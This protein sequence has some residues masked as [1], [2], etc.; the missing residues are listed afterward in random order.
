MT[1]PNPIRPID[2]ASLEEAARLLRAG[3]VVSFPT[4]TV[5]G[6]GAAATNAEAVAR[7]FELK[8]RPSFDPLIVHFPNRDM[9]GEYA[10]AIPERAEELMERFWP[11]P[12]T[13][14]FPKDERIPDIVT[15]GL[16]TFAARV[17]GHDAALALLDRTGLPLA[18]PS[19]N[20]FGRVS[21]TRARHV[22]EQLPSLSMILDGG[23]CAVGVES[24]ILRL[25]P[26]PLVLR[27]GGVTV[28]ELES[29]LGPVRVVGREEKLRSPGAHGRHYAT[30]TP[31]QLVENPSKVAAEQ[32]RN[33]ALLSILP[34]DDTSGFSQ[35]RI[36]AEDADLRHA[37]TQLFATMRE[38][39]V[40]GVSRIFVV[41]VEE[42]GLGRAIM[43]RLRRAALAAM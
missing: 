14:L 31:L 42:R 11:G 29:V 34:V 18:A 19:A 8:A 33:A 28:E 2:D 15:S 12:L 27:P 30:G 17:P 1:T 25:E 3:E 22:A 10:A 7:V 36:L 6:L 35:V 26:E 13:I 24:T 40:A 21:P 23:S 39:D 4:E 32:R 16:S 5:Y 37:A 9:I 38:L 43:D 41:G 20:V